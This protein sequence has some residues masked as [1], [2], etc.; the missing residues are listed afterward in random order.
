MKKITLMLCLVILTNTLFAQQRKALDKI[1]GKVDNYYILRS[2]LEAT[3]AQYADQPQKPSNC[4]I[5]EQLFIG[6]LLL[7]KSEIDSVTVEDK[8]VDN[9]LTGRMEQM[10]QRFGN[11]KNI[12]E[13]YGRSLESLK[14]EI[15]EIHEIRN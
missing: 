7:A 12:V 10:I 11:E 2:D 4:Q 13:A 9:E 3:L 1:I 8:A 15:H 6:K 14:S 5:L